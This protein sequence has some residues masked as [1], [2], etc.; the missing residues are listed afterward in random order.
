MTKTYMLINQ[1]KLQTVEIFHHN[2]QNKN[3]I[4]VH[5][6]FN[7]AST[8]ECH[9]QTYTHTHGPNVLITLHC[10][11]SVSE[12]MQAA[13]YN[14]MCSVPIRCVVIIMKR[15]KIFTF[16]VYNYIIKTQHNKLWSRMEEKLCFSSSFL[17]ERA[18]QREKERHHNK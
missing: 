11:I 10:M 8:A 14:Y 13:W 9:T 16:C 17:I 2:F 7:A 3:E 12:C 6:Q 4:I 1:N 5:H 18:R 15:W